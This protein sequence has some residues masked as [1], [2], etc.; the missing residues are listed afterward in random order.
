MKPASLHRRILFPL[1]LCGGLLFALLF[2]YFSPFFSPGENRR[3][4]A[5]VEERFHS[6]VTSS[7]ITLHYTLADPASRGIAPGTASFGTVSIPDRT[8]YDALLQSVETTLTSFHRNR[9]SAENQITLDLLL[10]ELDCEKMPG[11]TS[12]LAEPLGP[13][14][15]IQA[16][17]PILL[18]EYPFRTQQDIADYLHLLQ[19]LPRYFSD[20]IALEQEKSRQG[21]FQNDLAVDGIIRQCNAFLADADTPESHL[22]HTVFQNKLQASSLFSEAERNLCLQTHEKLLISCVFPAYRSLSD[23]LSSLRG[24]GTQN[25]GGLSRQEGGLSYY[26][27]LLRSRVGVDASPEEL[28]RL[29]TQQLADQCAEMQI[30][31]DQN[32]SLSLSEQALVLPFSTPEEMLAD[33]QNAVSEDFPVLS[34]IAYEVKTVD[35]SL[36]DFLSPAFYLTPPMDTGTPNVIYINPAASYQ[37]LELF[38]TLAHEGFPGHLYQTVTFQRQKSSNI[39]NLLCTSG[40]AEGWATYI[41]PYAYQYAADYIQDPSATELARISWLNRS[42]NLC[43]YSLLDIEIHY[44]GWTQA[45]AASFL[46][47]FGIEDSAVVSEIYQYILETPGNYL[48]YYWGYLSLLDLRTSEQNRLGQDFDLKAFHNQV[49]KIG[50]VQFPVLEKYIDAEF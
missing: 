48:K 24:K 28:T 40:F 46:K 3:F 10:Y 5:Y 20:L 25:A 31:L 19:D 38:T 27:Y 41:E 23:A 11:S 30:I 1:L 37:G 26:A 35:D 43:M 50:G 16:Q 21:V 36:K 2:W 47:A 18:A 34:G 12:L 14:L 39:R 9:L 33:L 15:G 8:S 4:S 22:L 29:L 13:S 32:P 44:N 42:I 49:L 45:E 7:A 17:L 6:E